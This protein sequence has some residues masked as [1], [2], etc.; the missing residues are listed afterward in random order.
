MLEYLTDIELVRHCRNVCD[1]AD[2]HLPI[3]DEVYELCNRLQAA[4]DGLEQQESC[5]D[6]LESKLD[7]I[8]CAAATV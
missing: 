8:A 2:K 5:I 1:K 7:E 6:E 4:V 3:H